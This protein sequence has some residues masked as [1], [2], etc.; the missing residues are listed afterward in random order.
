[1]DGDND[2]FILQKAIFLQIEKSGN[3]DR[4]PARVK[5]LLQDEQTTR[6]RHDPDHKP[7]YPFADSDNC[8]SRPETG[9]ST[10]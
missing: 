9:V 7:E 1:V 10:Q 6:N 4:D 3:T 8:P 5:N 2:V